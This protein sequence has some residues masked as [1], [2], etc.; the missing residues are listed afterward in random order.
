[1]LTLPNHVSL[2]NLTNIRSLNAGVL[3]ARAW[4]TLR[5]VVQGVTPRRRDWSH[6]R[7]R[8]TATAEHRGALT[9]ECVAAS[10]AASADDLAVAG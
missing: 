3:T 2:G 6:R 8:R 10:S 7:R 4:D 9:R 1:M 5:A